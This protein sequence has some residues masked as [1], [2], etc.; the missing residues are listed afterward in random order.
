ML[1][2]FGDSPPSNKKITGISVDICSGLHDTLYFPNHNG[3]ILSYEFSASN[4]GQ[5]I[6]KLRGHQGGVNAVAFRKSTLQLYSAGQDGEIMSWSPSSLFKRTSEN[7]DR[8]RKREQEALGGGGDDDWC[9]DEEGTD[10]EPH[11]FVPPILR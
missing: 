7:S 3:E 11:G 5:P 6:Q 4:T 8:K 10:G 9:S 1:V 2:N